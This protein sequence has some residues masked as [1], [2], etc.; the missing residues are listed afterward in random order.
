MGPGG[1]D[2]RSF[3]DGGRRPPRGDGGEKGSAGLAGGLQP[4]LQFVGKA[5][6]VFGSFEGIRCEGPAHEFR[7]SAEVGN[8][9]EVGR[10]FQGR[11]D[12]GHQFVQDDAQR[13]D[14]G[15][16]AGRCGIVQDFGGHVA[17]GSRF[18]AGAHVV[19]P[20]GQSEVTQN[21]FEFA[22][23]QDAGR[24]D[25]AVEEGVL[26]GFPES[27]GH[28]LHDLGGLDRFDFPALGGAMEDVAVD[29]LHH[30]VEHAGHLS[31]VV[32]P[33]QVG[34]GQFGHGAGFHLETPGEGFDSGEFGRE[35]LDGDVPA[36]GNL[37][38]AVD[39][40][41]VPAA[42]QFVEQEGR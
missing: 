39:G 32:D 19:G 14:V 38:G 42:D 29:E 24:L 6:P 20:P 18:H 36:E 23:D 22:G 27:A 12:T 8:K 33:D 26:V 16:R 40:S 30:E 34:V 41:P 4:G 28:S 10:R 15:S 11:R 7:Q 31:E 9:G 13:V 25:V 1:E 21:W 37:L 3:E 2:C 5:L 35:H 17:G